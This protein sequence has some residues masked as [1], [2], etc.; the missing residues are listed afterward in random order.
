MQ[1]VETSE[2]ASGCRRVNITP[3]IKLGEDKRFV[4][5][6]KGFAISTP[7]G[8]REVAQEI[9]RLVA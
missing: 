2:V 6:G 3:V 1:W 5:T 4:E 8:V 7:R 9:E